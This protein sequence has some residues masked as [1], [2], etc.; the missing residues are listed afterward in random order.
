VQPFCVFAWTFMA[1]SSSFIDVESSARRNSY[2]YYGNNS[3]NYSFC[4]G[5]CFLLLYEFVGKMFQNK[6]EK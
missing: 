4:H 1:E 2:S 5:F 6:G 3:Q